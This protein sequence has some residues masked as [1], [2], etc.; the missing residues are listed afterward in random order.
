LDIKKDDLPNI[1]ADY[2]NQQAAEEEKS[3]QNKKS[4]CAI[5]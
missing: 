3:K 5:M 4:R 2:D 1:V